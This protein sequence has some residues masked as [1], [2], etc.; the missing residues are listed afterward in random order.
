MGS[1]KPCSPFEQV[2]K[3]SFLQD[4]G[5][6]GGKWSICA[7]FNYGLNWSPGLARYLVALKP[8]TALEFGAGLGIHAG[9]LASHSAST[10]T[11]I[12]PD[13]LLAKFISNVVATKGV[14]KSLSMNIFEQDS[15]T[16]QCTDDLTSTKHDLVT[17]FEVIEHIPSKFH[18]KLVSFLAQSTGMWLVFSGAR[19][20]QGGTG[21]L[22]GSMKTRETWRETFEKAG[23]VYMP[24]MTRVARDSAFWTRMYDLHYNILVFKNRTNMAEDTDIPPPE[25]LEYKYGGLRRPEIAPKWEQVPDSLESKAWSQIND[26]IEEETSTMW[27][28]ASAMSKKKC[29]D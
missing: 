20:S 12:E 22:E 2:A 21:H 5:D 7:H 3:R 14:V 11:T 9:Y 8:K 19:P 10:V 23:L 17:S 1:L 27:P 6:E 18:D 16:K 4:I 24:K 29:H 26:E 15:A 25:L 28:V 13:I